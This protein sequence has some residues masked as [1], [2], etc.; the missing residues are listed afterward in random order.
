MKIAPLPTKLLAIAAALLALWLA[1]VVF[2]YT[3]PVVYL[4]YSASATTPVTYFFNEDN[5]IVKDEI[6]PGARLEFRTT[7]RPRAGYFINVSLPAAS[8]DGVDIAPP[9]S[10]VDVYIGAD[11]KI[12]RTVVRTDF[13]ARFGSD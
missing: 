13:L 1:L 7:H 8:R 12:A 6:A 4:H 2:S 5:D 11:T 3:S 9:F 10:R